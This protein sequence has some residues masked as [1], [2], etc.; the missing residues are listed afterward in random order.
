M[1]ERLLETH[2]LIGQDLDLDLLI[3]FMHITYTIGKTLFLLNGIL[4]GS[5]GLGIG[6]V[7]RYN[8]LEN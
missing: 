7:N 4:Y 5:H 1:G 2:T 6:L 8:R 3:I